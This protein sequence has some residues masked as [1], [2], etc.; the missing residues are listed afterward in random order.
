MNI[1]PILQQAV[2]GDAEAQFSLGNIYFFEYMA[3]S[4]HLV[5]N[6][7]IAARWYEK[8]ASRGH[9]GA[10]CQLGYMYSGNGLGYDYDKATDLFAKAALQGDVTSMWNL[11]KHFGN[12]H[13][14]PK[15]PDL[16]EA[17]FLEAATRGYSEDKYSMGFK[18]QYGMFG[19]PKDVERMLYWYVE[20]ARLKNANAL[21]ALATLY[22]NGK[23]LEE[24]LEMAVDLTDLADYLDPPPTTNE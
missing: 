21:R 20:A 5:V 1:G 11:G 9:P 17:W 24:D 14:V 15:R 13:G 8:A 16:A 10:Q 6:R 19:L 18:Y 7:K 3:R 2:S 4:Y 23:I 12:G 22:A